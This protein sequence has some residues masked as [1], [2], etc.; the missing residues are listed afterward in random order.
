MGGWGH[1]SQP[2]TSDAILLFVTTAA[3]A[4][5][6][7]GPRLSRLASEL[8]G[9]EI[10]RIGAEVRAAAATGRPV[11]NLTI[12]DFSP[13][14]FR[15][16]KV[17]EEGI[18]DALRAGEYT[19][20]PSNGLEI[21]REALR[22]FYLERIGLDFPL[23]S[24]LI[25]SGARP[26]IYSLFRAVVSEG[27]AVVYGVPSWNNNYYAQ[28]VRAR[29]LPVTCDASTNFLPT[30]RLLAPVIRGAR[31]LSLNSPLNP[32]GTMFDRQVLADIGDLVL[33]ENARRKPGEGPLYLMYDQ[34][35]WMVT[36]GD[37]E[38]VDP[39]TLRPDLAPYT[40]VVDAISKAFAATGL[41][42]GWALG[43]ADVIRAMSDIS[44]HVG[45]WAPRPEQVA[46]TRM[47]ANTAALDEYI[48]G[49]C[50]DATAR[51]TALADGLTAMQ[52]AGLPVQ[53]IK[54]QGAIYVSVQFDLRGRR[55]PAGQPLETNDQI[56]KYLLD[57]A[58][59]GAVPFQAFGLPGDTGWFRLSI[60]VVSVDGIKALLP[61]IRDAIAATQ[62]TATTAFS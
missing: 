31:L 5:T 24:V 23:E 29:D 15:I 52:A 47:F 2:V 13:K 33:E 56:R 60:G 62:P 35:Y 32:T 53:C 1:R 6:T 41:R 44:G 3:A 11:T 22:K 18:S 9:S 48:G 28:I 4:V 58:G 39:L 61:R 38:H 21:L 10:L 45:A 25:T 8:T 16:P 17:L 57:S 7:T 43:P 49:M 26:A 14:E 36:A 34:V 27:D 37:V 54:P 12:G 30:A 46:T 20:P 55:G 50:R 42:V 51:L 19:Y 59:L 40:I